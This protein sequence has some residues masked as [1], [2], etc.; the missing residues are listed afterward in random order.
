MKE[1]QLQKI[2][3]EAGFLRNKD[4]SISDKY[5]IIFILVICCF[6][7]P[8]C[9]SFYWSFKDHPLPEYALKLLSLIIRNG[10]YIVGAFAGFQSF[11]N[12]SFIKN[13]LKD[14]KEDKDGAREE[15]K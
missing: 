1:E 8:S 10:T 12:S 11:E 15:D 7:I 14:N 3:K 6:T 4:G 13:L 2:K 9:I 5:L